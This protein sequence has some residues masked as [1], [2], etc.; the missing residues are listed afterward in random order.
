ME[1]EV[2]NKFLTVQH[3]YPDFHLTMHSY[4]CNCKTS[5]LRLEVHVDYK[6]LA[7]EELDTL[8]WAAADIPITQKLMEN[9]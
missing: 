5:E 1:I 2:E 7:V 4:I 3:S 6:W 9:K 8:D